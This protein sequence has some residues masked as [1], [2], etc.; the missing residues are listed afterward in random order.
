MP[1]KGYELLVEQWDVI[2]NRYVYGRR[3]HLKH[4]CAL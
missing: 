1:R 3:Q 2:F 4:I